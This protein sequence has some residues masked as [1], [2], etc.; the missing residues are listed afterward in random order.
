MNVSVRL[1]KFGISFS[2]ASAVFTRRSVSDTSM[3]IDNVLHS[4]SKLNST[5]HNTAQHI[6]DHKSIS[7]L[8]NNLFKSE[9][10]DE[11]DNL[12][13]R[14][15]INSSPLGIQTT[16]LKS[17]IARQNWKDAIKLFGV[18]V[19]LCGEYVKK[20]FSLSIIAQNNYDKSHYYIYLKGT[21]FRGTYFC[22]FWPF[23]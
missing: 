7:I 9:R 6:G 5:N 18:S 20:I 2:T 15:D 19:F 23:Q 3:T 4:F 16:V 22:V 14:M 21:N 12:I 17:Y 1:R 8:A 10:Y 13:S 11:F